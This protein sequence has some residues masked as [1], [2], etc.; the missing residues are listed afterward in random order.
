MMSQKALW[1]CIFFAL[2]TLPY[3]Q[4][5]WRYLPEVPSHGVETRTAR[6]TYSFRGFW[7]GTYQE[8]FEKWLGQKIGFRGVFVRTDNQINYS[9]FNQFSSHSRFQ[10]VLGKDR[11]LF[12]RSYVTAYEKN[13]PMSE[14]HLVAA[15]RWLKRVQHEL[16]L[17]DKGFLLV[18][19][20]SK[21]NLYEE[22]L[23][24]DVRRRKD[25]APSNYERMLPLLRAEKIQVLDTV[26]MLKDLKGKGVTAFSRGSTHWTFS[27]SCIVA[28]ETM[29][30]FETQTGQRYP[31]M[32]CSPLK[33][34]SSPIAQDMDLA[35]LSNLWFP[36]SFSEPLSYAK[37]RPSSAGAT[38]IP[39]MASVGSSFM[40]SILHYLDA[41]KVY[42]DR[43]FY[44]YFNTKYTYPPTQARS[45]NRKTFDFDKEILSKDL[46]LIEINESVIHSVG[47]GVLPRLVKHLVATRSK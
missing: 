7:D 14:A 6:P 36:E 4:T 26:S 22:Y 10:V 47:F 18:I 13:K 9:L 32:P 1:T 31:A 37:P 19:S 43:S 16:Q 30:R 20:P 35:T 45:V 44:Y 39:T 17:R 5:K 21:A 46:F 11:Y 28:A 27:S 38:A 24:D 23:P 29:R 33:L 42:K 34:Q 25:R 8:Q 2:T 40:W 15:V 12:G 3:T 41:Y